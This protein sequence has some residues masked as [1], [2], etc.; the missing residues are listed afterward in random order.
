MRRK[1]RCMVLTF[2]TTTDAMAMETKCTALSI[3]GRL[4]P[5]P[6]DISAGCGLAW[7]ISF[8]DYEVYKTGIDQLGISFQERAALLL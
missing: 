3:P 7:K 1:T 5:V 6:G 8:E 4:I 2:Y